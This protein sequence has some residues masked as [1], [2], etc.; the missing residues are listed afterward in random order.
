MSDNLKTVPGHLKSVVHLTIEESI[1]MSNESYDR[2]LQSLEDSRISFTLMVD[3]MEPHRVVDTMIDAYK[4][5][6]LSEGR[7]KKIWEDR[8][9]IAKSAVL[10]LV[11]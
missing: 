4:K 9:T 2:Y 1:R 7:E 10:R 6:T 8:Y 11:G 5:Y 3:H